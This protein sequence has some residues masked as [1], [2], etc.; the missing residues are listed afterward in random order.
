[1]NINEKLAKEFSLKQEYS[2]NIIDLINQGCTI[3]F[4]ARYRKEMHGACDDQVLRQ[5]ADRLTYLNN[6]EARKAE[7]QKSI[8]SQ[9]KWTDELANAL[10]KAETM[11]EVEDIYR[12]Y[13]KKKK[14]RASV[15]IERGLSELADIIMSDITEGNIVEIALPFVNAEKEVNTIEDAYN[16]AKDIVAER[17]SDDA[18]LRKELRESIVGL[19]NIVTTLDEE[20]ENAHVYGMYKDFT[21]KIKALPSH[22][23]LAINRGEKEDYLKVDIQLDSQIA[24]DI[25]NNKYVHIGGLFESLMIEVGI[26]AYNR[27]I[28]PSV[29]REVRNDL[30]D[31]ANEGAIKI[32]ETNLKPLLMQSPLK[33]CRV[34][35]LDPAYRTGC[36]IAVI[37]ENGNVLETAVVYPTP[38]QSKVEEAKA[39]LKA[40]IEKHLVDTISIGNGTASKEAEIFVADLIKEVN[41]PVQY[42]VVS[43]A[44]ASVYSASELGAEEFPDYDVS[45]RSAVSIGRRLQDPLAE[46]IKIDAKSIGVGQYQHDMPQKRLTE[47]LEGVV[48]DCV[49]SVGVDLNTASYKL[50]SYVSGLNINTAKN[51]VKYRQ[52]KPFVSRKELLKV[53]KLGPKA[54]E[55]CAGFLRITDGEE[56]LDNTAVHPEAYSATHKLLAEFGYTEQDIKANNLGGLAEKV[57]EFG[58]IVKLSEKLEIGV[59]TLQ[60]ILSEIAKPGRDIRDSLPKPILRDDLLD[61]KDLKEG[62]EILGTVR[63]VID[64]G[65]FIDIGV[66]QDG[67]VHLSEISNDYIKH[68]SE[69]LTVGDIV[70]V[71][72]IGVDV[73]KNRISLTIRGASN[74][75]PK[76]ESTVK[77]PKLRSKSGNNGANAK[78]GNYNNKDRNKKNQNNRN[79]NRNRAR[80]NATPNL[81]DMLAKLQQKYSKR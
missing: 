57:Q 52:D 2:N 78:S 61:I 81:D 22:R 28:F 3:P 65:A 59:P 71:K 26:D 79:D 1:M 32:F 72:V 17:I 9:E 73:A 46:L 80:E 34:L 38:P 8:E 41:R 13:K 49:N 37:D 20:K 12:P 21:E 23:I 62:M 27:L 63:N 56:V 4:I 69:A 6:L 14:T 24:L 44:G 47:V 40:L 75:K 25:I 15:A 33:N 64:F 54:Y 35:A 7:V 5:F 10:A 29:A 77:D 68:P 45:L 76:S 42:A 50:L 53:S 36:K 58:G 67:L 19:G 51:I 48:E 66:H 18:E 70:T 16:G 74:A 30:T 11:T 55:Q 39:K 60:D 43:E 31:K